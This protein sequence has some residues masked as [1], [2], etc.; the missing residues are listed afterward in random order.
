M[1]RLT[2][3]VVI[4]G[5]CL[6]FGGLVCSL[7]FYLEESKRVQK[8]FFL[9]IWCYCFYRWLQLYLGIL[10]EMFREE[11]TTDG[12]KI[13]ETTQT[14]VITSITSA[15]WLVGFL[16]PKCHDWSLFS[17]KLLTFVSII[18]LCA[19]SIYC[20]VNLLFINIVN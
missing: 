18:N 16:I 20:L 2:V 10:I 1:G 4:T 9:I 7:Y 12:V 17:V 11:Y 5:S 19:A 3:G 13:K 14:I 8:W 15:I 6:L